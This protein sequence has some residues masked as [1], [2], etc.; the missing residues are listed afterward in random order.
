MSFHKHV[1]FFLKSKAF[2][3]TTSLHLRPLCRRADYGCYPIAD[4]GASISGAPPKLFRGSL[5][6]SETCHMITNTVRKTRGV[7]PVRATEPVV[8]VL[9]PATA[10]SPVVQVTAE[11]ETTH[12]S[13]MS[14]Y[15][16]YSIFNFFQNFATCSAGEI[17]GDP[18]CG[19]ATF[20]PLRCRLRAASRCRKTRGDGPVRAT[21]PA[22]QVLVP[23][24]A[25][26]P[27]AQVTAETDFS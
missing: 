5:R 26:S 6:G 23:A 22:E 14:P 13:D 4:A 7:V 19:V 8:Q 15:N 10:V 21:E 17:R 18:L 24:T 25:E 16:R 12:R 11:T 20:T 27:A 9:V 2:G 1:T 3:F